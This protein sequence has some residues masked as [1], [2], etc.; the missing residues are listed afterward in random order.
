MIVLDDRP[1]TKGEVRMALPFSSE[2][3][4]F[5]VSSSEVTSGGRRWW[6]NCAW[7]SFA[8]V[9]ALDID[10]R[11][12]ATWMDTGEPVDITITSGV[13]SDGLDGDDEGFVHFA[14][15]ASRWWDDIVET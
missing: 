15:P 5:E 13:I 6:A 8:V 3:T 11:I 12:E 10:S 9:A 2:P 4:G 7:D 14:V 1:T